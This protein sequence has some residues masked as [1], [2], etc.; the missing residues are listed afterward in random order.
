M[1]GQQ[2]ISCYYGG[3]V[4]GR[5]L[6]IDFKVDYTSCRGFTPGGSLREYVG[7][8]TR[9]YLKVTAKNVLEQ[10]PKFSFDIEEYKILCRRWTQEI[11]GRKKKVCKY[12]Y[13]IKLKKEGMPNKY[14]LIYKELSKKYPNHYINIFETD[15]FIYARTLTKSGL[16][17]IKHERK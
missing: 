1:R 14:P 11:Y 13:F 16:A 4:C 5:G 10:A 3:L 9:E 8:D 15:I 2:C 17:K 7:I 12:S 6:E